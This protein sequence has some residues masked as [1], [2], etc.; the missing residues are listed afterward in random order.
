MAEPK[1]RTRRSDERAE[2]TTTRR[3]RADADAHVDDE[4]EPTQRRRKT[5]EPVRRQ[6]AEQG[7]A[8]DRRTATRSTTRRADGSRPGKGERPGESRPESDD[9]SSGTRPPRREPTRGIGARQAAV[10]AAGYVQELTGTQPEGLTS[11]DHSDDGWRIGVE[12]LE[13]RRVP[14]STDILAEYQVDLD[15]DGDLVAYRRERRYHR[16]RVEG[17]Q[18]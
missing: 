9:R 11:L 1:P 18:Q 3:R 10:A 4:S 16:G 14:D 7:E 5:S 8:P 12:V 17:D 13:S 6:R 15:R 2:R